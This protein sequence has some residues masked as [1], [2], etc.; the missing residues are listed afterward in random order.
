MDPQK[1]DSNNLELEV[2]SKSLWSE[3]FFHITEFYCPLCKKPRKV[4]FRSR[5]GGWRHLLAVYAATAFFVLVTWSWFGIRGFVAV[6]PIWAIFETAYRLQLRAA[7]KC[8]HCGF[9]PVLYLV[10]VKRARSAVEAH[11]R[12]VF[13]EKG[14]PFPDKNKGVKKAPSIPVGVADV[15]AAQQKETAKPA[16][17]VPASEKNN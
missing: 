9:D 4:P 7:L 2:L 16:Q 12:G 17:E 3:R 1:I 15:A 14:V 13:E 8:R 11:Y 5:P 6:V 10:D